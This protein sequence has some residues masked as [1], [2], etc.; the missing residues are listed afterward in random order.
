MNLHGIEF[1]PFSVLHESILLVNGKIVNPYYGMALSKEQ[2]VAGMKKS[3]LNLDEKINILN[4]SNGKPE[5]RCEEISTYFQIGKTTGTSI[6]KDG[7]ELRKE[8]EF[9]K[10]KKCETKDTG[11]FSLINKRLCKWSGKCFATGLYPFG[12]YFLKV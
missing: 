8:F 1:A 6:V 5:K 12:H 2:L 11:Q 7:K 4:Y 3:S 10:S 9:F